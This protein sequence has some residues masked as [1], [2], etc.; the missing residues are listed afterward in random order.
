[1]V[2]AVLSGVVLRVQPKLLTQALGPFPI[3]KFAHEL[4]KKHIPW[5]NAAALP[6]SITKKFPGTAANYVL[7]N[8]IRDCLEARV[9]RPGQR[10]W[11]ALDMK[12][13]SV[14]PDERFEARPACAAL[15]QSLSNS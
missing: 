7:P 8:R 15:G 10:R 14:N 9:K 3:E 13:T 11:N 1:M 6:R 2:E 12:N 4:L 5:S